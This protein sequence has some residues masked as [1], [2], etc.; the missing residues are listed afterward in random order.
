MHCVNLFNIILQ[1]YREGHISFFASNTYLFYQIYLLFVGRDLV[2][3]HIIF[4]VRIK[5]DLR[6]L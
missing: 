2:T 6:M 4:I 1:L 3:L 5:I